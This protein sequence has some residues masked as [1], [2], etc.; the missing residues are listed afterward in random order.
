[1]SFFLSSTAP[2]IAGV[3]ASRKHAYHGAA[4]YV[5]HLEELLKKA[6]K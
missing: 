2:N 6:P 3:A 5:S 1:M 4:K